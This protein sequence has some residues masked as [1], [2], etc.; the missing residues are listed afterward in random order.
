MIMIIRLIDQCLFD[1]IASSEPDRTVPGSWPGLQRRRPKHGLDKKPHCAGTREPVAVA[2]PLEGNKAALPRRR[3]RTAS[4]HRAGRTYS[5][6]PRG[7][8]P[9]ELAAR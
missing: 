2:S 7:G 9:V 3:R 4:R 6:A 8:T 5:G 1:K